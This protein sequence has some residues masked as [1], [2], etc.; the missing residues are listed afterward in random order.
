MLLEVCHVSI[1]GVRRS[2]NVI[3]HHTSTI[4]CKANSTADCSVPMLN[5]LYIYISTSR[6]TCAVPIWLLSVVP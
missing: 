3:Y 2:C 4:S 5:V 1:D 6:R